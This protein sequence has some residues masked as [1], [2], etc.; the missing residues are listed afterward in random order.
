MPAIRGLIKSER[1]EIKILNQLKRFTDKTTFFYN[2][3][4]SMA[5]TARFCGFPQGLN[6]EELH[7][8]KLQ[9]AFHLAT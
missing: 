8:G 6:Q 7:P 4:H 9:R 2:S 1:R 3:F 5:P